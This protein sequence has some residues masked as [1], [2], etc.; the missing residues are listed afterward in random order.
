MD[1]QDQRKTSPTGHESH[2]VYLC[3]K[4]GWPF[5]NPHPSAK[6]R[7]A[8]KR[9]CGTL[10]GYK[11]IDS[12]DHAHSSVSDD[13]HGSD[14]DR[15]TPSPKLQKRSSNEFGRGAVGERSNRSE[16]EVFSDAV[17]EFSDAGFIPINEEPLEGARISDKNSK[18]AEGDR[19]PNRQ[20][21]ADATI[22]NFQLMSSPPEM[23]NMHNH[24]ALQTETNLPGSVIPAEDITSNSYSDLLI[25]SSNGTEEPAAGQGSSSDSAGDLLH[26]KSQTLPSSPKEDGRRNA[27]DHEIQSL[28]M[29]PEQKSGAE[30]GNEDSNRD[31]VLSDVAMRL[32]TV[33]SDASEASCTLQGA[34]RKMSDSVTA[35]QD[36]ESKQEES[37]VNPFQH[38]GILV[39]TT[40][41][42]SDSSQG[43]DVVNQ[44]NSVDGAKGEGNEDGHV[45]SVANIV[46]ATSHPELMIEDFKDHRI[47]KSNLPST[48]D[49]GEVIKPVGVEDCSQDKDVD[50][51]GNSVD[52][53]KGKE[54]EDK[55]V[56][57]VANITPAIDHSK[58]MVEDFKDHRTLKPYVPVTVDSGE[59]TE[60][61]VGEDI[62]CGKNS[63]C[64]HSNN[65]AEISPPS[66]AE[67]PVFEGNS[68]QKDG[69][70]GASVISVAKLPVEGETDTSGSQVSCQD[71]GS[72]AAGAPPKKNSSGKVDTDINIEVAHPCD[73][74]DAQLQSALPGSTTIGLSMSTA[75]DKVGHQSGRSGGDDSYNQ[76]KDNAT[77]NHD[78]NGE[79]NRKVVEVEH[80]MNME[81]SSGSG[82]DFSVPKSDQTISL[83]GAGNISDH[84]MFGH[85]V[86]DLSRDESRNVA[87]HEKY[88]I[89]TNMIPESA[90]A[91]PESEV[92]DVKDVVAL[93]P[94]DVSSDAN[95]SGVAALTCTGSQNKQD[96]DSQNAMKEPK[97]YISSVADENASSVCEGAKSDCHIDVE[98][99]QKTS[100]TTP[101][102]L[103]PESGILV[104]SSSTD[105]DTHCRVGGLAGSGISSEC[106]KE[107]GDEN[108]AKHPIEVPAI[109]VSVDSSSQTD[110]VEGNWGSVSVS[111]QS[112]ALIAV[113]TEALPLAASEAP[114]QS[115]KVNTQKAKAT[116][117]GQH[118]EESDNFDPPS[119]MTLVESGDRSD[120]ESAQNSQQPKP[121]ALQAGW[122]P[123]ITNV[124][125]ESQG[126]KKNEEIIAKVTNWSTDKQHTNLKSLLG[127]ANVESQQKSPDPNQTLTGTKKEE[128]TA[129]NSEPPATK[130]S[131]ILGSE[132]PYN[133]V[134]QTEMGKDWNSAATL[135]P[136]NKKEKRKVK[137]RPYWVPFVCCSSVN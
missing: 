79:V 31:G 69:G 125:N 115:E 33:A 124:V 118:P 42:E 82:D 132:A 10:E 72:N 26:I 20:L 108:L 68:K 28:K 21:K 52:D 105:D 19:A 84:E 133:Q 23:S 25:R 47:L 122:F 22:C 110:S 100:E 89:N 81:A 57:S 49:Y 41:I 131:S 58:A 32:S 130:V 104:K 3:H 62:K 76:E 109:D 38:M 123:S 55:H 128:S 39:N 59:V 56:L 46:P 97:I 60:P 134:T 53:A 51:Q 85:G 137:G 112:D 77:E 44:G 99:S 95:Q 101:E 80:S 114:E 102:D 103:R 14:E 87:V 5:P 6:H 121:E 11:L 37:K 135:L 71:L 120:T 24:G 34:V 65:S 9:I 18:I 61:V 113:D 67:L 91:F 116:S 94:S 107:E 73:F 4:C 30:G 54:N 74:H 117:E 45:V 36:L 16:D 92:E 35:D 129:K 50:S 78:T 48:M 90:Y 13:E 93:D 40:Q 86:S 2:G 43:K 63:S 126:R 111:T 119:F 75:D 66:S 70:S 88:E 12:E 29:V 96:E 27:C 83:P 1:S 64:F 15:K 98:V 7:R 127:E 106:V 8:H 17:T 136:E